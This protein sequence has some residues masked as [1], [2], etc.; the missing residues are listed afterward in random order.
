MDF[1]SGVSIRAS[2]FIDNLTVSV[3]GTGVLQSFLLSTPDYGSQFI[4]R[5]SHI[6][7]TPNL[8][9][10]DFLSFFYPKQDST[11]LCK[12]VLQDNVFRNCSGRF[13]GK[14]L[15][16]IIV[17]GNTFYNCGETVTNK[18]VLLFSEVDSMLVSGNRFYDDRGTVLDSFVHVFGNFL[19]SGKQNRMMTGNIFNGLATAYI[20]PA[21]VKV[22]NNLNGD[23]LIEPSVLSVTGTMVDNTDPANP[24]ILSDSTKVDKE[25]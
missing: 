11:S 2:L 16:D 21:N 10:A 24:V 13:G 22:S 23:T 17:T 8:T 19:T 3:T 14:K 6:E 4:M 15:K 18:T 5:N 20:V 12:F 9:T 7:A 1:S 25:V